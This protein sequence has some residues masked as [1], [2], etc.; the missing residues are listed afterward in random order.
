MKGLKHVK[1]PLVE[2]KG[3]HPG[4]SRVW[5]KDET[6]QLSG[7][8]KFRGVASYFANAC[9]QTSVVTASTGNHGTAVAMMARSADLS[10]HVFVPIH[11]SDNKKGRLRAASATVSEVAGSYQDCEVAARQFSEAN[12]FQF[13]HSFEEE[14]VIEGHASLLQEIRLEAPDLP[15]LFVPVGGGGLL[16]ACLRHVSSQCRVIGVEYSEAPALLQSL[17]SGF[18]VTVTTKPD[19]VEGLSVPQ[20]GNK[21][22]EAGMRCKPEIALVTLREME[23]ATWLAW[24]HNGIQC[25]LAGAA[26]LAAALKRNESCGECACVLSGGNVDESLFSF[27]VNSDWDLEP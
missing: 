10:A 6:A 23:R 1:T 18:R 24:H 5:L 27:I 8:F 9:P 12:G 2:Y 25:E 26:A 13:I 15:M 19:A 11:I 16:T 21:V 7:A 4:W 22:F 3:P 17:T 14:G 20:I